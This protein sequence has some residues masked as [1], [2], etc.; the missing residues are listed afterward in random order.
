MHSF[1]RSP[2]S[3]SIASS[4][5]RLELPVSLEL[6]LSE[7]LGANTLLH[8]RL[9]EAGQAPFTASLPGVHGT[10]PGQEALRFTVDPSEIHLFDPVTQQRL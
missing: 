10:S 8:G 1:V 5:S 3:I 4:L 9:V 2:I 6:Q 7:P